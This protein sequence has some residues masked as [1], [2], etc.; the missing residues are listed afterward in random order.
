M[1]ASI[2]FKVNNNFA[3]FRNTIN[4][5][6]FP[7]GQTGTYTLRLSYREKATEKRLKKVAEF[8]ITLTHTVET[9]KKNKSK[10]ARPKPQKSRSDNR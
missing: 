4:F 6:F 8:P 3:N 5:P 7:I 2:D 1:T 9:A 10:P